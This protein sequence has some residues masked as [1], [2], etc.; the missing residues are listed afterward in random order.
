MSPCEFL[1]KCSFFGKYQESRMAAC[2]GFIQQYCKGAQQGAC[3]R[4]AYRKEH[5][6]APPADMLP[7]GVVLRAS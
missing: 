4:K 6:E 1:E 5:N 7:N 2:Q 3:K